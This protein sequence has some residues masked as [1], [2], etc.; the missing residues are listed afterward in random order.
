MEPLR[1]SA[2]LDQP[3]ARLSGGEQQR[4]AL[5]LALGT[6]ADLFVIDEPSAYLDSE[7]RLVAA[8]VLKRFVQQT[9]KTAF[10][11]EHDFMMATFLSTDR[12]VVYQ[13]EPA[14]ATA[15][16]PLRKGMNSF[17]R[18]LDVTFRRDPDTYR[19]RI[20]KPDSNADKEQKAAGNFFF[21]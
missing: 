8:R 2:L 5:A 21:D 4:V 20:N 17:L 10:V 13:G 6:P 18:T 9:A 1:V 14:V 15:P 12:V 19:P 3:T 11:V 16:Q 7:Q